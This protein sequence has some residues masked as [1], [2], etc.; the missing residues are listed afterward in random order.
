MIERWVRGWFLIELMRVSD[1]GALDRAA[2]M[3]AVVE[4]VRWTGPD[5]LMLVTDW[6]GL[7]TI[8]KVYRGQR[9]G[10]R[11]RGAGGWPLW[12]RFFRR[13]PLW[14][15]GLVLF[16]AGLYLLSSLIWSVEVAGVERIDSREVLERA[17]ALGIRPGAWRPGREEIEVL[18]GKLLQA[19]PDAGWVGIHM[20]GT[21]VTIEVVE[22]IKPKELEEPGDPRNVVAAKRG[23][24]ETVLVRRGVA[25]VHR[26]QTVGPGDILVSGVMPDG[27]TVPAEGTVLAHVWYTS[28]IAVPL[29]GRQL[30]LTGEKRARE[31]LIFGKWAVPIWGQAHIPF[32][33]YEIREEDVPLKAA[34]RTWPVGWRHVEY[35]EASGREWTLAREQAVE[36]GL[37]AVRSDLLARAKPGA[38]VAGQKILH[39]EWKNGNLYMTVWTDVLE[40][41][42]MAQPVAGPGPSPPAP[43]FPD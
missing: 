42:G 17:E 32:A 23:V 29:K 7:R 41:I 27:R 28:E 10:M 2:R 39:L 1:G 8:R 13:R 9:V 40:D 38:R 12:V 30:G 18:Q 37:A 5:S 43:G 11:I 19:L 4:Q 36:R 26:G 16:V 25:R 21:R 34:G 6:A 31:Y 3:G 15:A 35:W 22:Q 33:E 24:V 20:S 14:T